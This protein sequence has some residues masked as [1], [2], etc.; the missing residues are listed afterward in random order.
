M[1]HIAKLK[2]QSIEGIAKHLTAKTQ[3]IRREDIKGY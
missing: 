3:V 1:L 2:D